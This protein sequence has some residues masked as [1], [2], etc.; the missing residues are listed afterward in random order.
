M[1]LSF[2]E[3]YSL[4]CLQLHHV[5]VHYLPMNSDAL[6]ASS[7]CLLLLQ[8]VLDSKNSA[9]KDLQYELARVCKVS[10]VALFVYSVVKMCVCVCACACVCVR[11]CV[12]ACMCVCVCVCAYVCVCVCV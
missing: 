7:P 3:Q 12:C 6:H 1:V 5:R 10:V 4:I 11:T 2:S 9:I 8:D